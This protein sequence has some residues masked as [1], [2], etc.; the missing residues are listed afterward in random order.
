[1]NA[2]RRLHRRIITTASAIHRYTLASSA[3]GICC[4]HTTSQSTINYHT[5]AKDH[6]ASLVRFR[7]GGGRELLHFRI[8]GFTHHA[9]CAVPD[10]GNGSDG[11]GTGFRHDGGV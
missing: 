10:R 11:Q 9:Y 4:P 7:G 6:H 2:L 8:Q 3:S 5:H 1:M